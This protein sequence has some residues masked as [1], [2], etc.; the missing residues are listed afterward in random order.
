MKNVR[1]P[2][3]LVPVLL[4][5][6]LIAFAVVPSAKADAIYSYNELSE[7]EHRCRRCHGRR[8][9]YGDRFGADS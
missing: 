3:L 5:S 4:V 1:L 9:V 6:A 2:R 8:R 7:Y